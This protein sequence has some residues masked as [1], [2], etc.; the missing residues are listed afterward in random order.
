MKFSINQ[1]NWNRKLTSRL[2]LIVH[3][4]DNGPS[5]FKSKPINLFFKIY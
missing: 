3:T 2:K 1:K 4:A 5:G